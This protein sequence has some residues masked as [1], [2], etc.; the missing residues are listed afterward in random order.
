MQ[1]LGR[2]L[3]FGA[4]LWGYL[5][6]Y[7]VRCGRSVARSQQLPLETIGQKLDKS[8][9]SHEISRLCQFDS[10]AANLPSGRAG[11]RRYTIGKFLVEPVFRYQ[12]Q[13]LSKALFLGSY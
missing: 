4:V 7:W 1:W 2:C 10:H 9:Q 3:D 6:S 8:W 13:R 12:S 5:P 11:H